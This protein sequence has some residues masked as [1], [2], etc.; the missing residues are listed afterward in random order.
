MNRQ[1]LFKLYGKQSVSPDGPET[2]SNTL[3]IPNRYRA[4]F[5]RV[6]YRRDGIPEQVILIDVY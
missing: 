4:S 2:S 5:S 1:A 6:K 3:H